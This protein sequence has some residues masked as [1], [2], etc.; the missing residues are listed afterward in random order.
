MGKLTGSEV[1]EMLNE[2][3]TEK[4]EKGTTAVSI[5]ELDQKID[6]ITSIDDCDDSDED[7]EC[8]L[9]EKLDEVSDKLTELLEKFN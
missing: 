8:E 5:I 9:S 7:N 2:W 3:I 1:I 6:D 4:E